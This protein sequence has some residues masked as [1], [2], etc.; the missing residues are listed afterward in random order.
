MKNVIKQFLFEK[1]AILRLVFFVLVDA[2]FISISV[3]LAFIVRFEGQIPDQYFLN[4]LGII[5]LATLITL[6]I[7]Y[8]S[9]LYYFTWVY[10]STTELITL[11][12][13]TSLSFLLLAASFLILRDQSI[14]T[15]FPR[16]TLF[17]SYFFIFIFSG[18][19]RFAK[20][21]YLEIFAAKN[22]RSK[23]KI[24]IV[25]AGDAGEQLLRNIVSSKNSLYRPIGFVDDAIAKQGILIH[26][27][28]VLGKIK[29]IH[30]IVKAEKVESLII[31]LPSA[32]SRTIKEA[33]EGGRKAGVQNIKIIP[34]VGEMIDGQVSI[35]DLREIQVED[36][37]GREPVVLDKA[38]IES[39]IKDKKIIVTGAAG[40]IGSELSQQIAK[41][42]PSALLLLDQDETGIFNISEELSDSF[43]K[44]KTIPL[45]TNIQDEV[46]I[47]GVFQEFQPNI[48]F[49]A[50]AYKHV[51][52]M[53]NQPEEAIKNNILGTE[54]VAGAA[55]NQK[56][57]KFIFISTDKAVNP[58][59]V[60]GAT[61]RIGEMVC[62]T[63]NQKNITKF[64]SVRFGNVLDSRGSV[65][66]TF[67]AQIKKGGPVEITHSEME[68][69]FMTTP[70]ACLLVLQAGAIGEGGEV[71][72][73]DMGDPIKIVDLAKELIRLS[74][75]EPD[76]DIPIVFTKPRPGEKFFE[77]ILMAE[78]GIL[79]TK[80][81]KI[82]VAKIT[83]IDESKL[84]F[85]IEELK[86][87]VYNRERK[88]IINK[89]K[90]I[91]PSY[92]NN[93]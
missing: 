43:P 17:I 69:Y 26:G 74:G 80:N 62:Q 63:L 78:E 72:I 37:L 91:I 33:V 73:L 24:L 84:L 39:F 1:R 36:L 68:R 32:G 38:S 47:K 35:G 8:F 55:F 51:P 4:I 93:G 19:I 53:E 44:L 7:F 15:G 20:R 65:I 42:K 28:K 27:L 89:L 41:F 40:S 52:L 30:W 31:A 2:I 86:K 46:K 3:Y 61:K 59:S 70:E 57:E 92:N 22:Q 90:E 21:I 10:V 75:K 23:E 76:K 60:M 14:F 83:N 48:V 66:P 58:T 6:P 45:V 29:D 25:G 88:E 54:I 87:T 11:S 49:H 50:A 71:F 81:Q 34:S 67:R 18:G 9:K 82:F 79:N 85:N 77:E 5:F 12:K 64:I 56:V 16:S 13:A